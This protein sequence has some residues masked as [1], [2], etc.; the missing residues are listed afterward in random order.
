MKVPQF[1][2]TVAL[3]AICLLLSI[4]SIMLTK[5]SQNLQTQF[6]AQQEEINKGD[7][8]NRVGQNLLHDMA[9]LSVKNTKIAEVLKANGY[10]VNVNPSATPAQ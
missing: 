1:Y 8:G 4:T 9:E 3:G 6:Q 10:T 5:S 2:I 7:L